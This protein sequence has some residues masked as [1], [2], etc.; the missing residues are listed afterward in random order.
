LKRVW[1]PIIPEKIDDTPP[2][3]A[4]TIFK[5]TAFSPGNT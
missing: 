5:K 1:S 3:P 4:N 2:E